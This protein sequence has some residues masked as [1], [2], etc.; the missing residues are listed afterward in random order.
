MQKQNQFVSECKPALETRKKPPDALQDMVWTVTTGD[1][2]TTHGPGI[3]QSYEYLGELKP[4]ICL[5]QYLAN[6]GKVPLAFA[7]NF[8]QQCR[9]DVCGP[10]QLEWMQRMRDCFWKKPVVGLKPSLFFE[11]EQPQRWWFSHSVELYNNEEEAAQQEWFSK[12]VGYTSAA[13]NVAQDPQR[14]LIDVQGSKRIVRGLSGRDAPACYPAASNKDQLRLLGDA[15]GLLLEKDS[16][17]IVGDV[18][19]DPPLS[20]RSVPP[21][22]VMTITAPTSCSQREVRL[23]DGDVPELQQTVRLHHVMEDALVGQK[24][25]VERSDFKDSSRYVPYFP[26]QTLSRSSDERLCERD[27][28][29][30]NLDTAGIVPEYQPKRKVVIDVEA[31][32]RLLK[33]DAPESST[34]S[35]GETPGSDSTCETDTQAAESDFESEG[36][37]V[38]VEKAQKKQTQGCR[39]RQATKNDMLMRLK[40]QDEDVWYVFEDPGPRKDPFQVSWAYRKQ[41]VVFLVPPYP[42][43]DITVKKI[44]Q[45][46]AKAVIVVPNRRDKP[47]FKALL[48]FVKA[49]YFYATNRELYEYF[50]RAGEVWKAPRTRW[51]TWGIL[52]D[53]HSPPEQPKELPN[54]EDPKVKPMKTNSSRRRFRKRHKVQLVC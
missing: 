21:P 42:Q 8:R 39:L 9:C 51:A 17:P 14:L 2:R 11:D 10:R 13:D 19:F 20:Q 43:L 45:D 7:G 27:A 47:W 6:Y 54:L 37:D 46:K 36:Q 40:I 33:R 12:P 41:G 18:W 32:E 25:P 49:R 38:G 44:I 34:D 5:K 22:P 29:R 23:S 31:D 1:T 48:P 24:A 35:E 26:S 28:P 15:Q 3:A 4:G 53:A 52:V 16:R 30:A 50:S